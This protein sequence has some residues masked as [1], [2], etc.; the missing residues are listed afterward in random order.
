VDRGGVAGELGGDS[1]EWV[2]L[3]EASGSDRDVLKN[4]KGVSRRPSNGI[5]ADGRPVR[6]PP[7][8]FVQGLGDVLERRAF[9]RG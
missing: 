5:G 1:P 4:T 9:G 3:A 2:A 6:M 8:E 7:S